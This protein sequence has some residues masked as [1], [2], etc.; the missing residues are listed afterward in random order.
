MEE[1]QWAGLLPRGDHT[2]VGTDTTTI[3]GTIGTGTTE[4]EGTITEVRATGAV[5]G[6]D[7]AAGMVEGITTTADPDGTGITTMDRVTIDG[8]EAAVEVTD[9]AIVAVLVVDR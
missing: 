1:D 9:R 4:E 6:V 7:T 5:T 3:R 2:V 8:V